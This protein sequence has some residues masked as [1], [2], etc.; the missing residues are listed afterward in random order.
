MKKNKNELHPLIKH[1]IDVIDKNEGKITFGLEQQGHISTIEKLL[2]EN[3]YG[4]YS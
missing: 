3:G 1:L 2:L 4:K